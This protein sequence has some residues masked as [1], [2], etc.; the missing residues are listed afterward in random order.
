MEV[1][2]FS[3]PNLKRIGYPK[4]TIYMKKDKPK[5]TILDNNELSIACYLKEHPFSL[6]LKEHNMDKREGTICC[7]GCY[8]L[9]K[10]SQRKE[11]IEMFEKMIDEW[12]KE[13]ITRPS[14]LTF[15]IEDLKQKLKE[16]K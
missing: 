9:G 4:N 2:S 12:S 11:D 3:P 14:P 1:K 7:Q 13:Q 6:Y 10:L 8:K 16:M 5:V 15:D